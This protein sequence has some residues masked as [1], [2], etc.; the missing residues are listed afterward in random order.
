MAGLLSGLSGLGLGNLESKEVF[1]KEEKADAVAAQAAKTPEALE[2]DFI[3]EKNMRC[4]VCDGSFN[5]KIMKTGKVKLIGTDFDLRPKYEGVDVVKYDA[6]LCPHCG[7]AAL[8]RYFEHISAGP[9]KLIRENISKNVQLHTYQDDIYTYEEAQERYTLCLAN[10][11]VKRAKSSE[12]A[13]ICL[14][15]AWLFRGYAEHL[16]AKGEGQSPKYKELKEQEEVYLQNAYDGF[17]EACS[18][19]LFPMCGM[20]EVTV[21]YLM[22]ELAAHFKKYDEANK[23]LSGILTSHNANPRTKDKARDLKDR[24]L[25]EKKKQG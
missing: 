1:G 14:K 9:A 12:K 23:L 20:D 15:S 22:A 4:P 13:Y 5:T 8:T 18:S 7:Y 25:E 3:Y 2:K 21:D 10:A 17:K 6:V 19:E 16:E 11:V 24:I